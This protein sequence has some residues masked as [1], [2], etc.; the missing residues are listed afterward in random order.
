MKPCPHHYDPTCEDCKAFHAEEKKKVEP[1]LESKPGAAPET[2]P[3]KRNEFKS[4]MANFFTLPRKLIALSLIGLVFF[5]CWL[6]VPGFLKPDTEVQLEKIKH[7]GRHYYVTDHSYYLCESVCLAFEVS[8]GDDRT[9]VHVSR[10]SINVQLRKDG[11]SCTTLLLK[12]QT[13]LCRDEYSS[14]TILVPRQED[15]AEWEQCIENLKVEWSQTCGPRRI[16]P[17]NK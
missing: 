3:V 7:T 6:L 12:D 8:E 14:A 13:V 17:S 1:K 4:R 2:K 10:F 11:R 5:G 9:T 15:V 16:L